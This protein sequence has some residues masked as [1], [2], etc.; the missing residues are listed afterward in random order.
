[1][2][3]ERWR[4]IERLY[5]A[6]LERSQSERAR[7]LADAC[8]GDETLQS[9]VESLIAHGLAAPDLLDAQPGLDLRAAIAAHLDERLSVPGH[10]C[11]RTFGPYALQALLA[12]GG[13]GEVYRAVDTRLNRTVAV[14]ILLHDPERRDVTR[15]A[16][17]VSSLNH[18]HI[19][20]IHDVGSD[21]GV[22]YIVMEYL[23]GETLQ[24]RLTRGALPLVRAVEYCMQIVDALD[25]AHR[26]GIVHRDIKPANVMLT[27]TGAKVLDFGIATRLTGGD[28][29]PPEDVDSDGRASRRTRMRFMATPPYGSPEQ[30]AGTPVDARA[31]IFSFGAVAYEMITGRRAFHGDSPAALVAS[32][33][34]DEPVPIRDLVPAVPEALART[35][36]RCLAK[37]PDERWQTANDLLFELR[38]LATAR[39]DPVVPDRAPWMLPWAER[40]LWAAAVITALM[41]YAFPERDPGGVARVTAGRSPLRAVAG[42]GNDVCLQ[43]RCAVRTRSRRPQSR[44]RRSWPRRIKRLWIRRLDET[45][46][47]AIEIAGTE[48]ANTPFWSPDGAWIGFFSSPSA[49]QGAPVGS[50]CPHHCDA[51]L[52]DGRRDL[53]RRRRHPVRGRTGRTVAGLCRGWSRRSCDRGR[54]QPLLAAVHR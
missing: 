52:D 17:I 49:P 45:G 39:T 21:D 26:R 12:A 2:T 6:A 16:E 10:Y 30:L 42:A 25:K 53:E 31:D 48:D 36:S 9:E 14:K 47:P 35:L 50:S 54:G 29:R 23:E 13:M 8:R 51:C 22:D 15:E 28:R 46:E 33:L 41:I 44:V 38:S 34:Q 19:C 24:Q 37:A 5:H 43:L 11:G 4:T 3:P 20:T 27:S 18:P 32:V 40:A 1:M 7:F